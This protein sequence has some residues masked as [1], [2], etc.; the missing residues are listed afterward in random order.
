MNSDLLTLLDRIGETY[1]AMI[2]PSSRHYLEISLGNVARSLGHTA[3]ANRYENEYV[4]VPLKTPV[5]G[6]KVRIDGRTFV[7]YRRH[8]S[9]YA[10]PGHIAKAAGMAGEAFVPNDSMILNVA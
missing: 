4:V 8:L 5:P 3:L 1:E 7:R 10:V 6:M 2:D 9:G